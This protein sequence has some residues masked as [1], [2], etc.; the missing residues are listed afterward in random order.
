MNIH[1][2]RLALIATS[3]LSLSLTVWAQSTATAARY[4][5][6]AISAYPPNISQGTGGPMMMLTASR[7][8]TLFAPIYTDYEDIDGDGEVDYTFKPTFKYYGYFDPDKCYGYDADHPAGARFE[9]VLYREPVN[10]RR[11]CPT[12]QSLWSGNFLN[13]ATMTRLDVVRKTL[14]GGHRIEDTLTDTTLQ[15]A[16]LAHDAHAFV[17][18]YSGADIGDYT[19]FSAAYLENAGLTLCSRGSERNGQGYPVL[20]MAKGNYSLWATTP[21][22]VCNWS[23]GPGG[24]AF[25]AKAQAFYGK[26]GPLAS[27][28]NDPKAHQTSLPDE[29]DDGARYGQLGPE[30]AIRVQACAS[31]LAGQGSERCGSYQNTS[32][33]L[34]KP[35]GLLQEFATSE[36]KQ[37]PVRAE[38]GLITGSFDENFRGGQLRKNVA[39]FNDEVDVASGRFCHLM[40]AGDAQSPSSCNGVSKATFANGGGADRPG[41]V[42]AFDRLRLFSAENYNIDAP[43]VS[44]PLPREVANGRYPS[45]GNPMSE[46][47]TQALAYFANL[48]MGD[49]AVG[50]GSRDAGLG[51][52]VGISA[53]DPL[54]DTAIDSVAG[55]SRQALYGRAI[56]R[57][58][59]MLAISSG[60]VTHD[61][62]EPGDAED[63]YGTAPAFLSRNGGGTDALRSLTNKVGEIEGINGTW[64]SVGSASG[65]FGVDCT[66]K[67]IGT[68]VTQG[69]ADVAGVCP[70]APAV[71]GTYLGAGAAFG[72]N[73]RAVRER[74]NLNSA[75]GAAV[76]DSNLPAH[77]LRVRSYAAT[78]SGGVARIEVPIPGKPGKFVYITPESSWDFQGF[79]GKQTNG[80]LMPG[81]MLTFRA[82]HATASSAAY[83][84][85]WNDA[86]FGG[87]YDMDIVGFLRWE[88]KPSSARPGAQELVVMTD[89]LNQEA[90]AR[91]A[92]GFSIIGA[93]SESLPSGYMPDGRYLTHGGMNYAASSDC[94]ALRA[95]GSSQFNLRCAYSAAG[96]NTGNGGSDG[97]AWP[98]TYNGSPVNFYEGGLNPPLTSSEV[99]TFLV[100]DGVADVTL[101][102]P[103]WYVAK[104]GS[105]DTGEKE[106]TWSSAAVPQGAN[107][108]KAV[109][110]DSARNDGAACATIGCA[111]GEPDGYFLA[112][113]PELL[114]ERLRSLLLAIT[115]ASNSAPAVSSTQL[116]AGSLKYTAGFS[117]E[118]FGGTVKAYVMDADGSFSSD[119]KWDASKNM[120]DAGLNRVVITDDGRSGLNFAWLSLNVNEQAAYRAALIR[121]GVSSPAT[122]AELSAL[123]VQADRIESLVDYL[124]G[125]DAKEGTSFRVR[126]DGVMGPIV[127]ST[128]W[129]QS[130]VVAARYTD[131]DFAAATPSYRDFVNTTKKAARALLWVG[132]NDGMLHGIDALLGAPVMSYVPSPLVGRLEASLSASV[133]E[134]VALMDGS[135]FTGD[136]LVASLPGFTPQ[137]ASRMWRTYLFSSLGRGGRALF[138]LDV[139]EP[140]T[141]AVASTAPNAFKWVFSS[142]DDADLGY[143]LQDPVRHPNS[144]QPSQIVHLNNGE[145]GLLV[146]NGHGSAQGRA[147]L[148]ILS[149]NGPSVPVATGSDRPQPI[150]SQETTSAAQASYRKILTSSD[151]NNGLM[152]AT[153]VDLDNN[154]TADVVYAT[155]LLGRI[156]KFDLR[157]ANPAEWQSALLDDQ[158]APKPFFTATNG[159]RAL[160]ITTAPV[161]FFPN[162]GGTMISFATGRAIESADFPD[163][164]IKQRFFTVWDKGRYAGD[165]ISPPIAAVTATATTPATDA[166]LNLL[167]SVTAS[168]TVGTG[169]NASSVPTFIRRELRRDATTGAVYQV[170]VNASG[171][172]VTRNGQEVRVEGNLSTQDFD[173]AVHDGWYMDFPTNGEA[174]ISSPLRRLNFIVFTTVRPKSQTEREQ[175]CTIGPDG[176]LYAFNPVNG[177]PIRSLLADGSMDMGV[178]IDGQEIALASLAGDDVSTGGKLRDVALT[179]KPDGGDK[180]LTSSASN[181]RLQWR[182][183]T[184]MRTRS[185]KS[186]SGG[187]TQSSQTQTQSE[188]Q[189]P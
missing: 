30:L 28:A 55:L 33:A 96:M 57:P 17:K 152:G 168:R 44:F 135:P 118:G 150:W 172:I 69:L 144:G 145:F 181:L 146:P 13:W 46:M 161:A 81:A 182:E 39:S 129:L 97:F 112:R 45:W 16:A 163:T 140:A 148:F 43:G 62:D 99:K 117:Q 48:P 56:C 128:P 104:Y 18:Y 49:N 91:G 67:R 173:L 170:Q 87:D 32:T 153:W 61:T 70:E 169:T 151:G 58:M 185:S 8:H 63:V 1:L 4:T 120:A 186:S 116:I 80:D 108:A 107:G 187:T 26:Y 166:V 157:S 78:L 84:V 167:P 89:I 60:A 10:G 9:P 79:D 94:A 179:S 180:P 53:T 178:R 136:V 139:S 15:M 100:T 11:T 171:E 127:N 59:H 76:I 109:N 12:G 85:T 23:A 141:L 82:I 2:P 7:D 22:T 184:G 98:T 121:T 40:P 155:D 174:M 147:A 31:E 183:I 142:Q 14:Y 137:G 103:L 42:R 175:S 21:G 65:G 74:G 50:A 25:G 159:T 124:R 125:D 133:R 176:T 113:R 162:F 52:P 138:A 123:T 47:I 119:P 115:Q 177:L 72:A 77:A 132:S 73:T 154:G 66:V 106:F 88:I 5:S 83:V 110:W 19:P 20:R 36:Q 86:Q 149:V 54:N 111:D 41:I 143:Q 105:F 93:V 71:K 27:A 101:R 35:I 134:P 64:R 68:V 156:W 160:S 131:L 92:H 75:N 6:S 51:L 114:E 37:Q 34:R 122:S 24:F 90:G 165:Q 3:L 29:T 188:T 164:S 189:Q 126:R 38:F 158:S 95:A 102:D 130:P